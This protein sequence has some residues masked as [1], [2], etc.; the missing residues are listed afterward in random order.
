M[1]VSMDHTGSTL[2]WALC[3]KPLNKKLI[4]PESVDLLDWQ[5]ACGPKTNHLDEIAKVNDR[6]R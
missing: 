6:V 2:L 4:N 3:Y 5:T 1:C